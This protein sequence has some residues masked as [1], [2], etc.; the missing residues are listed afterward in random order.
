MIVP[1]YADLSKRSGWGDDFDITASN[2]ATV[3]RYFVGA[4]TGTAAGCSITSAAG[5]P[6]VEV[7]ASGST[8]TG[9]TRWVTS[10]TA[11]GFGGN[12]G[13][14]CAYQLVQV[15]TLSTASEE[16]VLKIGFGQFTGTVGADPSDGAYVVYDRATA[17]SDVWGAKACA[18]SLEA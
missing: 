7:F 1:D 4:A 18:S 9:G 13:E 8:N 16:Y 15:P 11:Y 3:G 6:S 5:H 14:Q 12:A 17:G 2:C 10:A